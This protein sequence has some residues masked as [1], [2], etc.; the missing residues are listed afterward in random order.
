MAINPGALYPTK[1]NP[2]SGAWPLGEPRNV[3]SAGVGDG[4]PWEVGV[5][6]DIMG[7]Q[8]AILTEGGITASGTPETA[9]ASQYLEGLSA[10][11]G[12]Q[13]GATTDIL[14]ASLASEI[15][16]RTL[17]YAVATDGGGALW[18]ATGVTTPGKAG[19]TEF[20]LGFIYDVDGLQFKIGPGPINPR[21]YGAVGDAVTDDLQAFQDAN[22]TLV[23]RGGG[24]LE[25][26][27]GTFFLDDQ[28]TLGDRV[29]V[30]GMGASTS[31]ISFAG[32]AGSFSDGACIYAEGSSAALPDLASDLDAGDVVVTLNA[33]HG[34]V[35]DDLFYV[36]DP[37]NNSY[38]SE[39]TA[40]R[41]G[42]FLLATRIPSTTTVRIS[43]PANATTNPAVNGS[44]VDYDAT[45]CDVKK[46]T[47]VRVAI[48]DVSI[49]GI[50]SS[51][52]TQVVGVD[53]G[54]ACRFARL[55]LSNSIT[56]MINMARSYDTE[57]VDIDMVN[58]TITGFYNGIRLSYCQDVICDRI[59]GGG[60]YSTVDTYA[61]TAITD[62][63]V[64]RN[65]LVANC[66]ASSQGG[67]LGSVW[68][69]QNT[70]H[71]QITNCRL[72]GVVLAG[73]FS[74]VSNCDIQNWDQSTGGFG[75]A[76]KFEALT[77]SDLLISNCRLEARA[78]LDTGIG[79]VHWDDTAVM[80]KSGTI[81]ISDC[82]V[83]LQGIS[84]DMFHLV[85][86]DTATYPRLKVKGVRFEGSSVA[87]DE[88][89][90]SSGASSGWR[91][92][93]FNGCNLRAAGMD[94]QGARDLIIS[95]C[96]IDLSPGPGI[97]VSAPSSSPF[98]DR[99]III[100]GCR[101]E[102]SYDAGIEITD[103]TVDVKCIGTTSLRNNVNATKS[104]DRSSF[105]FEPSSAG[106]TSLLLKGCVFGDDAA[107]QTQTFSYHYVDVDTVID[108]DTTILGGLPVTRTPTLSDTLSN[109]WDEQAGVTRNTNAI[110]ISDG[111]P[112][113]APATANDLVLGNG[114]G[115]KGI[116]MKA[117]TTSESTLT[118]G[119]TTSAE[120]FKIEFRHNTSEIHINFAATSFMFFDS[121]SFTPTTAGVG[122]IGQ[123]LKRWD[124]VYSFQVHTGRIF[125]DSGT[126]LNTGSHVALSAGW[127]TGNSVNV[128]SYGRDSAVQIIIDS[129]TSTGANPTFTYTYPDGATPGTTSPIVQVTGF[130]TNTST[131]HVI[132]A[133][134]TIAT[135]RYIGTPSDSTQYGCN[136]TLV[137]TDD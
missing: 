104:T 96:D 78:P 53:F 100:R 29:S 113:S 63:V 128:A 117:G 90:V 3:S 94:F 101:I 37:R 47:P 81:D 7:L 93:E 69:Q 66:I 82:L 2:A 86:R 76:I 121:N 31:I 71:I 62:G 39:D 24:V 105:V 56:G 64:N 91:S 17:G 30:R 88:V 9:T 46:V 79:L 15:G 59:R 130:G 13:R 135:I 67:L 11:F 118:A 8:Q 5:V 73:N 23:G 123:N 65:I 126:I 10:I 111:R 57:F 136:V 48:R 72:A 116:Y 89:L 4:T 26:D 127:G 36:V 61:D 38:G 16:V 25:L 20:N 115:D 33:V 43:E 120:R 106:L 68:C 103:T 19:T 129:G 60:S 44:S 108:S 41:A 49:V 99:E 74:Q 70:E 98:T 83:D 35:A 77:G 84:G 14:T 137:W 125:M 110:G 119:D 6:K 112:G 22:D 85:A 32:A 133:S 45:Q 107:V 97:L 80:H 50:S 55:K 21:Q 95:D 1:M 109:V 114:V 27:E 40:Y 58:E 18:I 122:D 132:S 131:W 102:A 28:L 51:S 134:S 42:E 87:N 12:R 124:A 54:R 34:L 75:A 52:I 92:V